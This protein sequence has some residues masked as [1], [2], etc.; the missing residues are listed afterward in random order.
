MNCVKLRAVLSQGYGFTSEVPAAFF[1]SRTDF[2][3]DDTLCFVDAGSGLFGLCVV[4]CRTVFGLGDATAV[5]ENLALGDV[6]FLLR[7]RR[8]Q[9]D[10]AE[11]FVSAAGLGRGFF[12]AAGLHGVHVGLVRRGAFGAS[13]LHGRAFA[14]LPACEFFRSDGTLDRS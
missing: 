5:V 13:A 12:V 9:P 3:F 6:D 2:N 1:G 11:A 4:F 8:H 7:I 14:F 10:L